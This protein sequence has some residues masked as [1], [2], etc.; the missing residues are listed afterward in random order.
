MSLRIHLFSSYCFCLCNE[1]HFASPPTTKERESWQMSRIC[2]LFPFLQDAHSSSSNNNKQ[3]L[4]R[5]TAEAI[6]CWVGWGDLG[7][8]GKLKVIH[9]SSAAGFKKPLQVVTKES[10]IVRILK[11]LV[12]YSSPL[13]G[14][15]AVLL[16]LAT[17]SASAVKIVR[18]SVP[19][20]AT[21]ASKLT[22]D[23]DLEGERLRAARWF[24]WDV[25]DGGY[26]EL[27]RSG[28]FA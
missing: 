9:P 25:W 2:F 26:R 12:M 8:E 21:S 3:H 15:V 10:P 14:L 13:A 11:A 20:N 6:R 5:R 27:Y 18:F 1:Q 22:C 16:L 4:I 28:A 7:N 23:Y 19:Q 17:G 24:L